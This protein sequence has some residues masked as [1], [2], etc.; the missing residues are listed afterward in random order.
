MNSLS[1]ILGVSAGVGVGNLFVAHYLRN[2]S[3]GNSLGFSLLCFVV[4]VIF[5]VVAVKLGFI[6]A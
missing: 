3:W 5:M 4:N 1:F 2:M 6:R